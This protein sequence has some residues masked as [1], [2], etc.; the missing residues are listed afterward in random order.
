MTNRFTLKSIDWLKGLIMG[1][2][3]PVLILVQQ[4]IPTWTP[5]LSEHLG[6]DGGVITQAALSAFAAYVLKN[7]L[8]NDIPVAQKTLVDAA[9]KAPT[10]EEQQSLTAPIVQAQINH[11]K[12]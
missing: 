7:Y 3:T 1:V 9:K 11:P 4:L 10:A 5:F 8:T 2:G 12:P 6:K